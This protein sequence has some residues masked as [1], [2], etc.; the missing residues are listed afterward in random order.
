MDQGPERSGRAALVLEGRV[1]PSA[2]DRRGKTIE[3]GRRRLASC[4]GWIVQ[5]VNSTTM[6]TGPLLGLGFG[7]AVLG[8]GGCTTARTL[9]ASPANRAAPLSDQGGLGLR[10]TKG[11]EVTVWVLTPEFRSD[12]REFNPPSFRVL[13]HNGGAQPFA[14]SADNITAF[15]GSSPV[16]VTTPAEYHAAVMQWARVQL[17][18]VYGQADKARAGSDNVQKVAET[19]DYQ[20][21]VGM[22]GQVLY[23]TFDHP[24][25]T[26]HHVMEQAKVQGAEIRAQAERLLNESQEMLTAA[27]VAPGQTAGGLVKLEPAQIRR[28]QPLRL[29]VTAGGEKH[30]FV[31]DVGS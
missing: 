11:N 25:E 26:N 14:L 27:T 1:L 24:A 13:V 3:T 18:K 21:S 28:G 20:R 7:L 9:S 16:H 17:E 12:P 5:L 2:D 30:E 10:S 22:R 15:S 4:Q 31:F 29:V 23:D 19:V 8:C 6:K